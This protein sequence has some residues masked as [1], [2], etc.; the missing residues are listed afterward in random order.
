MWRHAGTVRI[1]LSS[2]DTAKALNYILKKVKLQGGK[3]KY[4]L[5]CIWGLHRGIDNLSSWLWKSHQGKPKMLSSKPQE[6]GHKIQ[7]CKSSWKGS[8]AALGW[9]RCCTYLI[10]Y[11]RT[12]LITVPSGKIQ[13]K[14]VKWIKFSWRMSITTTSDQGLVI[15]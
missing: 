6:H 13:H 3:L 10:Y 11:Q 4:K 9:L 5:V 2:S 12:C 1:Q 8:Y 15:R 7:F 14:M